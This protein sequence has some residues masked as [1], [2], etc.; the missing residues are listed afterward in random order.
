MLKKIH[1]DEL[2]IDSFVILAYLFFSLSILSFVFL[3]IQH[4]SLE[5]NDGKSKKVG[6]ESIAD[7]K[8]AYE[9][10]TDTENSKLNY[11]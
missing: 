6:Y 11:V 8:R 3:F 1:I 5:M 10:I 7:N 9:L 4:L 2:H